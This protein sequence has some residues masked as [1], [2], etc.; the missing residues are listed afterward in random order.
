MCLSPITS[1]IR[2]SKPA[3]T[4][5][6]DKLWD[7]ISIMRPTEKPDK[8]VGRPAVPFRKVMDG[9]VYVLRTGC[10]WKTLPREYGSGSTCHRRLQEWVGLG[11]FKK[12]WVNVSKGYMMTEGIK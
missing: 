5:I 11:I 10:Q 1:R 9:I 7:R 4:G 8:T 12:L 3:I 6:P 2:L